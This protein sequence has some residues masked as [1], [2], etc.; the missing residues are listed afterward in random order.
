MAEVSPESAEVLKRYTRVAA[1][2]RAG[3]SVLRSLAAKGMK[4]QRDEAREVLNDD[5]AV[6]FAGRVM[7]AGKEGE[8][9][10]YSE[11]IFVKFDDEAKE[12]VCKAALRKLKLEIKRPVPFAKN[13][14][15][16]AGEEGIGRKI[17]EIADELLDKNEVELC[18]AEILREPVR[19]GVFPLQWH[20]KKMSIGGRSFDAHVNVEAA[21]AFTQGENTT[22]ALIDDGFD[23]DHDE[24]SSSGK[25]VFPRDTGGRSANPRPGTGDNHGTAC[26][27]VACADGRFGASGVAPRAK[28]MPI[29]NAGWLGSMEEA[30][31]FAW[32]ADH[33]ADVISCSWG[34]QDGVPGNPLVPLSDN[35]RL[36]MDYAV[37]HGRNGR[38]CVIFFAAGNGNE[39]VD[40]DGYASYSKVITVAACNA[41]GKRSWYS[42]FGNAV[43]CAFPSGDT[44]GLPRIWTTDRSGNAGYNQGNTQ[45]GDPAGN[46]TNSFSG[47]SSSTPGAAGIAALILSRNPS[48]TGDEVR[49][50]IKRSCDRIDTAGGQYNAEGRSPKYG[51]GRMNAKKAVELAQPPVLAGPLVVR[52]TREDRTI[53]DL[54]TASL[55]VP[56]ADATP[57]VEVKVRVDIEHTYIG[58][59]LVS[60]VPPRG[61]GA[62]P[63]IL[64]NRTGG[65]TRNI[66][67]TFDAASVPALAALIGQQPTGTWTLKV[68]DKDKGANGV[69][70]EVAVEMRL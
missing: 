60:L 1:V 58:D 52:S 48:L 13:A 49:D 43:W 6:Q 63:I 11:N 17:F 70:K 53:P 57:I 9:V 27:G 54:G 65:S 12:S 34:P 5:P 33:G 38:G 24:F 30:D 51:F 14:Y 25:I 10:L 18:H 35:T 31:A 42:D 47:T 39:S 29:R 55:A 26:A 69:L 68:Q 66:K 36:A 8:P 61:T 41:V 3:V 56:V 22:I 46:Y 64:H 62:G 7:L 2:P 23:I 4:S 19:K 44:S 59:L 32:A 21:W 40:Q 67:K 50:I 16:A 28:L 20:L 45:S 15:F 37:T